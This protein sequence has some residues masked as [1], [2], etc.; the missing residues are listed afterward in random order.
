[1]YHKLKKCLNSRTNHQRCSTEKDVPK[2]FTTFTGKH[3]CWSL[4]S[5]ELWPAT[6]LKRLQQRCC[7]VNIAKFSR[8]PILKKVCEQMLLQFL[9]LP[10]NISSQGLVSALSSIVPVQSP[11]HGL[12]SS[13]QGAQWQAPLLFEEKTNQPKMPLLVICCHSLHHS[14]SFVFTRCTTCCHTMQHSSVS[15]AIKCSVSLPDN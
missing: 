2:N 14:L 10:V 13:P 12:K 6:L 7:S 9:L 3:L 1:M 5:I 11:L 4:F 15:T 8:T